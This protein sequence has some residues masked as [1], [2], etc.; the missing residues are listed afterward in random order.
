MSTP[1]YSQLGKTVLAL[2]AEWFPAP[3][4][5]RRK[6]LLPKALFKYL[7]LLIK[8]EE[9]AFKFMCKYIKAAPVSLGRLTLIFS[10]SLFFFFN[11]DHRQ[12]FLPD[13]FIKLHYFN[14]HNL[15]QL[16]QLHISLASQFCKCFLYLSCRRSIAACCKI[17]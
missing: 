3:I 6:D 11:S 15:F 8:E 9:N 17:I 10:I 4:S 14:F 2:V 12:S 7:N 16:I 5:S 13:H 1:W